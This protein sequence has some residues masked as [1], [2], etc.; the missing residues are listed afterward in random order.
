MKEEK[1]QKGT[2]GMEEMMAVYQERAKPGA[3][4]RLLA[5]L[6]GTWTTRTRARM[7]ADAAPM[8]GTGSCEQKMIL[9]GRFLR[10]EYTGEMMGMTFTGVNLIG[11]DNHTGKFVSTW[12]DT[13]N[14]GIFYFEGSGDAEGKTMTRLSS[15][16]DPDRGPMTWRSV[17]R[18]VDENTLEYEMFLTPKGGRE[19][20]VS[21]MTLS[22]KTG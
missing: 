8:E 7:D 20:R 1:K 22:R 6:A 13:M 5:S 16:D 18:I 17:T 15:Y 3:P 12:V 19:E 21:E 2:M 14:T 4:H 10:Q 9:G 11:Y